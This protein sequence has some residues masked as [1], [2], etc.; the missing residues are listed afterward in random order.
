MKSLFFVGHATFKA[1]HYLS[2][3]S[4]WY[5]HLLL[6]RLITFHAAL[7][8]IL[9]DFFS[10]VMWHPERVSQRHVYQWRGFKRIF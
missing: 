9:E 5:F 2:R 8:V 4:T 10:R 6:V 3:V 7:D 1:V